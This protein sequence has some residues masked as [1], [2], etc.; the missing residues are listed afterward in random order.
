MY[1]QPPSTVERARRA[2]ANAFCKQTLSKQAFRHPYHHTLRNAPKGFPQSSHVDR[3]PLPIGRLLIPQSHPSQPDLT[4]AIVHPFPSQQRLPARH[5]V[6]KRHLHP[7]RTRPPLCPSPRHREP[8]GPLIRPPMPH[9]RPLPRDVLRHEIARHRPPR[10]RSLLEPL[11]VYSARLM[12]GIPRLPQ[13]PDRHM[14]P[15]R[16]SATRLPG[17]QR[18]EHPIAFTG[19]NVEVFHIVKSKRC[20]YPPQQ[21]LLTVQQLARIPTRRC[22]ERNPQYLLMAHPPHIQERHAPLVHRRSLTTIRPRLPLSS[23]LISHITSITTGKGTA[24]PSRRA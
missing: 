19:D 2:S 7:P 16:A 6:L 20:F 1:V 15:A 14:E 9:N 13:P 21:Q 11:H 23:P 24:S 22:R 17:P 3:C 18:M 8:K 10:T 12:Q 5:H 4:A